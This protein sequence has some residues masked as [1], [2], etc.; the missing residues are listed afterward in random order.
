MLVLLASASFA[1]GCASNEENIG[2]SETYIE[3]TAKQATPKCPSG[4]VLQCENRTIG[5][6]RFGRIGNKNIDS[7]AC[8][9]YQ[10]MPE[11]SPVPGI[12]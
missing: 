10:G 7:C 6:I 1:G 8:E 9:V 4:Y 12:Q 3:S 5:R 11:Q 2:P